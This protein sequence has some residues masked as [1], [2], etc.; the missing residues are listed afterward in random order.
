MSDTE[1]TTQPITPGRLDEI[2][3]LLPR[4]FS[5]PWRTEIDP[6]GYGVIMDNALPVAAVS[7]NLDEL[8]PFLSAAP[9]LVKELLAEVRR[10]RVELGKY[11][12]WEPTVK[13][14]YEHAV[15]QSEACA[16]AVRDFKRDHGHY[17]TDP[18]RDEAVTALIVAL[19]QALE[20][21]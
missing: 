15:G 8:L 18:G 21:W 4:I 5:G 7:Y 9:D 20:V 2:D 19:E 11:V 1:T 14:E 6:K 12:E 13:A 16:Q 3:A 17:I 10:Q